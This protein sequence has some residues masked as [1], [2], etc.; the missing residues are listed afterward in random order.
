[1][2][3]TTFTCLLLFDSTLASQPPISLED[4]AQLAAKATASHV[5]NYSITHFDEKLSQTTIISTTKVRDHKNSASK[6]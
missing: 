2:E 3:F 4:R 6:K 1:M 5:S